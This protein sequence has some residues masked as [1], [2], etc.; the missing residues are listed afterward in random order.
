MKNTEQTII[1][2]RTLLRAE[3]KAV[4]ST[5]S[6]S[7]AGY[8]FGSVTTYMTDYQGHPIIY[9]SHLAQ[10]TRNI[11][12]DPKVSLI[13]SQDHAHDINAGARLTLLGEAHLIDSAERDA[14]AEKFYRRFPASQAYQQTHDFEFYRIQV[15][16][17]RYIGGFG[18]IHWLKA[19]DF[20]LPEPTWLAH[21]QPAIAHMNEDHVD[22]MQLMCS[23]F[24]NFEADEIK[25]TH[26]YPDG[27]VLQCNDQVNHFFTYE[28]ILQTGQDIRK[29]LVKLTH[30]ARAGIEAVAVG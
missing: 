16:H 25:M 3:E 15:E 9:I 19:S 13:V 22:A 24:K 12:K 27:F 8:P 14:M 17:I 26:L 21:E 1:E 29:E 18:Q 6:V 11:K 28:N 7:K 10:H 5:H 30:A 20:L 4:L 2:A 23:Y